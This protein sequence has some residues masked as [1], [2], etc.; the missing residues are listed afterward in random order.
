LESLRDAGLRTA[1]REHLRGLPNGA[2]A[3]SLSESVADLR[4][5]SGLHALT[6]LE[7]GGTPVVDIEPLRSL[8]HLQKL[9]LSG[10][11]VSDLSPARSLEDLVTVGMT[12]APLEED[13]PLEALDGLQILVVSRSASG[14]LGGLSRRGD[15]AIHFVDD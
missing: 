3:G 2:D 9:W 5:L 15:L 11:K 8:R 7:L 10:T 14:R 13:S 6:V 4:P 1:V 12:G